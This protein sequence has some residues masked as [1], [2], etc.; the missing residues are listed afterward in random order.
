MV[1]EW[2]D[3]R[4][5]EGLYQVSNLGRILCFPKRSRKA[6]RYMNPQK[7]PIYLSYC[8]SKDNHK[9][10]IYAHRIVAE[11]FVPNPDNKP[12]VHHI[13]GDIYNNRADN[14][15]WV[16]ESEHGMLDGRGDRLNKEKAVC[17][18][19][20]NGNLIAEYASACEAQRK[21]G[22][23]QQN[24]SHCCLGKF[25]TKTAGGFIWKFK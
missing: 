7:R 21:T 9:H 23:W 24:I 8:L 14:L 4:G 19:D 1:E 20:L 13:D 12:F 11:A 15:Q 10:C 17:Q 22:I 2:K 5:Y 6:I 3:V 18:Y 25:Y 16:T